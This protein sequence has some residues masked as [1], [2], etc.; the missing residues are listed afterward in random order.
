MSMCRLSTWLILM[1]LAVG[2]S[3]T[4]A[5][6]D[7]VPNDPTVTIHRCNAPCDLGSFSSTSQSDPLV[8]TDADTT[9]NFVY[10]GTNP[11]GIMYV[12]IVPQEGESDAFFES[13][14]F[15]CVPGLAASCFSSSPA[16]PLPAV[17]FKFEGPV[18]DGVIQSFLN[19]GDIVGVVVAPEPGT[20]LLLLSGLVSLFAFGLR[21]RSV[22]VA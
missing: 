14:D 21:R 10:T 16:G 18:V 11:I 4:V 8:V 19:P 3:S 1:G 22:S 20:M 15:S 6:A 7:D 13:E 9:S 5:R 17:E 12:E 2:V